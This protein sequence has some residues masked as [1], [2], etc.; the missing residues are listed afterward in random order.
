MEKGFSQLEVFG[1]GL[2]PQQRSAIEQARPYIRGTAGNTSNNSNSVPGMLRIRTMNV[3]EGEQPQQQYSMVAYYAAGTGVMFLLFSMAAA[4]GAFLDETDTG[5]LERLLSTNASMTQV[6]LAKWLFLGLVGLMQIC[7]M[8]IWASVAFHMEL[9]TPARLAGFAAMAITTAAAASAFGLVLAGAC[10]TRAQLSGISTIVILIMSALGGSMV[11][12]FIMPKFME[13]T[14]LFTF[15]GWALDGF[16]KIFWYGDAR[17]TALQSVI[18]VAPQLAMLS[19]LAVVFL[20]TART[21]AR[22]WEAI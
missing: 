6:L 22:R 20:F 7:I 8:F 10:K 17:S 14:A 1:G 12:R 19:T 9:F 18:S 16:L 21:L 2:T 4:G 5:T 15:N 13:T 3:R 11:P